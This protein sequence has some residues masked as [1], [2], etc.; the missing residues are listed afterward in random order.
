[1]GRRTGLGG[2][3]AN[4]DDDGVKQTF[5]ADWGISADAGVL[6]AAPMPAA[7]V[8]TQALDLYQ[9]KLRRSSLTI[10]VVDYSG[11]MRGDGK[12]GVVDGLTQALDPTE[13]AKS[14]V[15]PTD[16]DANVL[17]P[18]SS[19]V[20]NAVVPTPTPPRPTP[21]ARAWTSSSPPRR[22]PSPMGRPRAS[23]PSRAT[24]S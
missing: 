24:S 5:R 21:T 9:T 3:V 8:T 1:M 22:R 7:D 14:M 11:S 6:K 18:F 10:W 23:R 17:I 4:P 20:I 13:S 12:K 15:Q 2:R 16:G 19:H